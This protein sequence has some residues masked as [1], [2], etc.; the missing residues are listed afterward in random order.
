MGFETFLREEWFTILQ[1]AG[2]IGGL[3]FTALSL[4]TDARIRRVSN[5]ITLTAHHREIW[6]ELYRRPEL[7]RVLKPVLPPDQLTPTPEEEVFV[8]LLILH[9]TSAYEAIKQGVLLPPEKLEDDICNFFSLPIP[10]AV[11]EQNRTYQNRHFVE[12]VEVI[13]GRT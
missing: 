9:L 12:F 6:T 2:I 7:A 3:L 8:S 10:K 4:R 13:K 5:L 1:S 11:W